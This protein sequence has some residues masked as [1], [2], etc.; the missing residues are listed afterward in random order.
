MESSP[1]EH[2]RE[3]RLLSSVRDRVV[4]FHDRHLKVSPLSEHMVE[5]YEQ[6][7]MSL[8][9]EKGK[10]IAEQLR[11]HMKSIAKNAE[12]G[13]AGLDFVVGLATTGL[14]ASA[15]RKK[16]LENQTE[17]AKLRDSVDKAFH[18]EMT[19][20]YMKEVGYAKLRGPK[21]LT[22]VGAG[23]LAFR[24]LTRLTD[25][26]MRM[27]RPVTV[28]ATR[29]VDAILLRNEPKPPVKQVFVGTGKA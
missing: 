27:L 14:G 8:R 7:A 18:K 13:M 20:G 1:V 2:Q 25:M 4:E 17:I 9:S 10:Q 6:V 26:S 12:I 28:F 15:W 11:P 21:K 19:V 23:I 5:T 3:K 29:K 16:S 22:A 24:P